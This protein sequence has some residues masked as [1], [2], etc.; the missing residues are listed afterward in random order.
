MML[1]TVAIMKLQSVVKIKIKALGRK[2]VCGVLVKN[3]LTDVRVLK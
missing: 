2:A 1:A 3:D